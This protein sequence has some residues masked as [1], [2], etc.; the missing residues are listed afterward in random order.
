MRQL[1]SRI[2]IT[3]IALVMMITAFPVAL[4]QDET[5]SEFDVGFEPVAEGFDQPVDLAHA[6]DGS[7]VLYIAEKP[8]TIR[9]IV[10]SERVD[11]PFLD[12]TDRVGSS[13]YEQGLLGLAFP[14]NYAD[15][16]V[17]YVN[18]TDLDGNTVVSRF[19]VADND[20]ADP[21]SEEVILTQVQPFPNHNGGQLKFGP[22]GYLYIGLGDGGSGGDPEGNGQ[23]LDTW[24][25]KILRLE[26]DP[27]IVP[28]G[29]PYAIPE[30]NP[31]IEQ[32]G[33]LPEIYAYGLRN[34]WRFSFDAETGDLLIADVGQDQ[35][36]EINLL[37]VNPDGALNFGWNITEGLDCFSS[38]ECDIT[39]INLPILTYTHAEGGCSVTGGEVYYGENLTDLYGTYIFAD[40]CSGLV[41]QGVRGDDGT[42]T[43]SAPVQSGL[44]ISSFGVDEA[45]EVYVLD[46]NSGIIY[47]M[48]APV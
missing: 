12:I 44:A 23:A 5:G 25:G 17:F 40:F 27:S 4:A 45:G 28:A 42:W 38:A 32:E 34:P 2:A 43:M 26:V 41:W 39:G 48:E 11:E 22:D 15:S 35:V 29:E 7:G 14:P 3:L 16:R 9:R 37:P 6:H 18:Y 31:L 36:E 8:G 20:L 10:D 46:L 13:G 47:R 1:A 21:A 33:A 19:H 30:D 24:L